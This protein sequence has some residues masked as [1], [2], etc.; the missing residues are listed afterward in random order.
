MEDEVTRRFNAKATQTGFLG[1]VRNN[2][3]LDS[4]TEGLTLSDSDAWFHRY[5]FHGD[6]ATQFIM[7][8]EFKEWDAK[9]TDSQRDTLHIANQLLRNRMNK[10]VEWHALEQKPRVS[11]CFSTMAG[12][13][14]N[15]ICYGVHCLQIGGDGTYAHWQPLKWDSKAITAEQL[16]SLLLFEID[17]DDFARIDYRP[18]QRHKRTEVMKE[19][20]TAL[21]FTIE[22]RIVT[23]S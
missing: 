19:H 9:L 23:Q 11:K 13:P 1:W 3:R 16:E 12:K 15:V 18:D 6:K 2:P 20:A 5:R 14:I 8:V 21:G 10:R 7:L 22:K 4:V 17:P